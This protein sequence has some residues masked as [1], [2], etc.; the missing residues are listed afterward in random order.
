MP[1]FT[2]ELGCF[3][4]LYSILSNER[5]VCLTDEQGFLDAYISEIF[6]LLPQPSLNFL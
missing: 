6:C 4:T 5:S 3:A 2:P 1:K